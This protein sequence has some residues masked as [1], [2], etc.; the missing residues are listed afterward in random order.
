MKNKFLKIL[1]TYLE[2]SRYRFMITDLNLR[3]TL[4]L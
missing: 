1:L 3:M 4:V 2:I